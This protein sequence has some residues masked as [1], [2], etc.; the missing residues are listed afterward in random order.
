MCRSHR[1]FTSM[2]SRS[3]SKSVPGATGQRRATG[4]NK[5]ALKVKSGEFFWD[6]EDKALLR[7]PQKLRDFLRYEACMNISTSNIVDHFEWSQQ[8]ELYPLSWDAILRDM[9]ALSRREHI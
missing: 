3:P 6:V 5:S 9:R 7:M 4:N 1:S 8:N 2:A